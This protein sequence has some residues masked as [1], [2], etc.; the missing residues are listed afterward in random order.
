MADLYVYTRDF[1]ML[2]S[3]ARRQKLFWRPVDTAAANC[4]AKAT[5]QGE[6]GNPQIITK[7]QYQAYYDSA[8]GIYRDD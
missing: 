5:R 6:T 7:N 1:Q 8:R 3:T 2:F 4:H